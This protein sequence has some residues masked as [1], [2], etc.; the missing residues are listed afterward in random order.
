[1]ILLE[2]ILVHDSE[3]KPYNEIFEQLIDDMEKY[4]IYRDLD[5]EV[6]LDH[7]EPLEFGTIYYFNVYQS[8]NDYLDYVQSFKLYRLI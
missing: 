7:T 1:M 3:N 6:D 4:P 5:F 8:N 2:Q